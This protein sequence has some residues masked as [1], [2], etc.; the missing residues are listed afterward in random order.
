VDPRTVAL[1]CVAAVVA[2]L[3]G[4]VPFGFILVK[5]LKG[6]DIRTVG[7]GNIGATNVARAAGAPAGFLAFFLD[8]AK[9]FLAATLVP[10]AFYLLARGVDAGTGTASFVRAM[11]AE[12]SITDLRMACGLLAIAGHNWTIFLGFKGGKGVA[13][14][15]GVLLGLAP[16]PTLVSL[17]VWAIVLGVSGYVSLGSIIAAGVLPIGYAVFSA[18]TATFEWRLFAF[19]VA[20]AGIV[21]LRHRGNMK[22]LLEGTENRFNFRR[23]R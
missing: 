18:R 16:W 21:I 5:A 11:V 22:R 1:Y 14:S 9:G 6:V 4:A 8:V 15:L 17:F 20:V 3:L 10:Y 2:Y 13:T 23:H 7:S 12:K 19:C